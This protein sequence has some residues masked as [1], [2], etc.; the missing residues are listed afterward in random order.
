MKKLV[1]W[2]ETP[3]FGDIIDFNVKRFE[4]SKNNRV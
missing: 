3:D 4:N 2:R 1:Y